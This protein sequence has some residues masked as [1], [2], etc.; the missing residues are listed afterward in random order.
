M[1]LAM[2]GRRPRAGGKGEWRCGDH[3]VRQQLPK[4]RGDAGWVP[5]LLGWCLQVLIKLFK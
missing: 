1:C 3:R 4:V 2:S 5:V